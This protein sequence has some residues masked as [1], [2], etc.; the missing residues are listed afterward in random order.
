MISNKHTKIVFPDSQ[1]QTIRRSKWRR[2][3][4]LRS[5]PRSIPTT[6]RSIQKHI[7]LLTIRLR[8][9]LRR[10]K[11]DPLLS[12]SANHQIM[13]RRSNIHIFLLFISLLLPH[14]RLLHPVNKHIRHS[15]PS[16][17]LSTPTSAPFLNHRVR[18]AL[19]RVEHDRKQ[20]RLRNAVRIASST[21]PIFAIQP[22]IIPIVLDLHQQQRR[23]VVRRFP[24]VNPRG[25]PHSSKCV[26]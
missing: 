21:P 12:A 9:V 10:I 6:Q 26:T 15:Y 20:Q 25:K 8:V 24:T 5:T 23:L 22:D 7:A 16:L 19:L 3:P 2:T 1:S 17:S 11:T 13:I 4:N 18:L 14:R